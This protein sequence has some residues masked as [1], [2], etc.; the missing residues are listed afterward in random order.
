MNPM[1]LPIYSC[2]SEVFTWTTN[3]GGVDILKDVFFILTQP[4][5]LKFSVLI[6][7]CYIEAIAQ[8]GLVNLV[9]TG[10]IATSTHLGQNPYLIPAETTAINTWSG[11]PLHFGSKSIQVMSKTTETL[12]PGPTLVFLRL[13][14]TANYI[15]K[16][17]WQ[18]LH[19]YVE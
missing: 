4:K 17:T 8:S 10:S 18:N 16:I 13:E 9:C 12:Q 3:S 11:S 14:L 2:T 7:G 1:Y 5:T 19:V 6:T 15:T